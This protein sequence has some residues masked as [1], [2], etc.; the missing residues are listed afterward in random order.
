MRDP[1]QTAPHAADTGGV[2]LSAASFASVYAEHM[3]ELT[4][5]CRSILR[6]SADAEDAAQ[7]AMERALR[8]L[9]GDAPPPEKVRPWLMTIAQ[10]EAI[11]LL[12]LRRRVTPAELDEASLG[13]QG[14]AEELAAVRERLAELLADVRELAP[15]QREVLVARELGG[16]SYRQIAATLGTSEAAAQQLVLEA[17]QSLRQFEAGRSLD[18][19]EVQ[20][21]MSA[22]ENA[23]VRTRRVRAHLRSCDGCRCFHRGIAAR[24]RDFGLLLPGVG[25]GGAWWSWLGGM[26]GHGGA[27]LVAG[28][29]VVVTGAAIVVA[30]PLLDRHPNLPVLSPG[31]E[32]VRAADALRAAPRLRNE[33]AARAAAAPAARRGRAAAPP[34]RARRAPG[35]ASKPQLHEAALRPAS[36][37]APAPAATREPAAEPPAAPAA[38]PTAAPA[39]AAPSAP[40]PPSG[41]PP[42][43][44]PEALQPVADAARPVTDAV[45]DAVNDAVE[46]LPVDLL[47]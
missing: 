24:R 44:T 8:A 46:A 13:P 29:A 23:R 26:L 19:H 45:G 21:W 28:G 5:Y 39:P 33:F 11:N 17:R 1:M 31:M 7:N 43:A 14:S 20:A 41:A 4:R 6:D 47:P 35:S 42:A 34:S 12:R 15:R 32:E 37:S 22:H 10:R 40:A 30:P 16:R 9:S 38:A 2:G 25:A 36:P 18:C 3:P 27:K